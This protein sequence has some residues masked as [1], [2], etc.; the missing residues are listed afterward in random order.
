MFDFSSIT[1][2]ALIA[3]VVVILGVVLIKYFNTD[4][5]ES[6]TEYA[7]PVSSSLK[8]ILKNPRK[9]V[10]KL[11]SIPPASKQVSWAR[12]KLK[13]RIRSPKDGRCRPV[14][15]AELKSRKKLSPL[16]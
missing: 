4:K 9:L 6:I 7:A 5:E 3:V 11:E 15:E 16:Q 13:D 12:N 10:K 14:L 8:G 2:R 1:V